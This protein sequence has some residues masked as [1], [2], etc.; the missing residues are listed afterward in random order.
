M[1]SAPC[2]RT[3]EKICCRPGLGGV[4]GAT[5]FITIN[6][7]V[8]TIIY[9]IYNYAFTVLDVLRMWMR[10]KQNIFLQTYIF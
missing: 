6:L 3:E 1:A 7:E 5:C 4:G 8:R 2:G 10:Q 9:I